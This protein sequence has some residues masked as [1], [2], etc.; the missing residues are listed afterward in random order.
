[1]IRVEDGAL[2]REIFDT[3]DEGAIASLFEEFVEQR[4]GRRATRTLAYNASSGC[5]AALLLDDGT[6]VVVKAHRPGRSPARLAS[7]QEVQRQ[8]RA[9]G[10]PAP[11]LLIP[12][13]PLG[14]GLGTI[15]SYL[16]GGS[17]PNGREPEQ[18][19]LMAVMLHRLTRALRPDELAHPPG[20]SWFTSVHRLWPRP[21]SPIFDF[22]ATA[23]GAEWIDDLAKRAR[24][25]ERAG[26]EVI[27]HFDWRVEHLR[28]SEGTI[29]AIYDWDA[30]HI[31]CE[32]IVVACAAHAFTACWDSNQP[33]PPPS[34]DEAR[35]FV[36]DYE[37]ARAASFDPAEKR[38]LAAAYVYATAYSARCAHALEGESGAGAVFIDTLRAHGDDVLLRG[39]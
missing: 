38:C 10:I 9:R 23:R 8:M 2:E 15:E 21:H 7:C 37:H 31:D 11:E 22:E 30:V 17:M 24:K 26:R 36:A 29:S 19:A 1:M 28:I 25:I 14:R 33:S 5:V 12:P 16:A 18:R 39:L 4:L 34:L 6:R 32:P 3:V 27:G 20:A 13:Q 35:A